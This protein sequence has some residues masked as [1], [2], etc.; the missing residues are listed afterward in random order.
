MS[1]LV[2]ALLRYDPMPV[3]LTTD[4]S[5]Q[6]L[7][8]KHGAKSETSCSEKKKKKKQNCVTF[9]SLMTRSVPGEIVPGEMGPMNLPE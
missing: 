8:Q 3:L 4:G 9:L 6:K 7:E 2:E 1:G 5:E